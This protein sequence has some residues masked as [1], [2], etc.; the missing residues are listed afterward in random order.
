MTL[1][2]PLA[3]RRA[4]QAQIARCRLAW[5]RIGA[6]YLAAFAAE[7][8]GTGDPGNTLRLRIALARVRFAWQRLT[9]ALARIGGR[10]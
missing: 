3:K 1:F 6:W 5:E 9:A 2:T 10:A 7:L 8:D 4:L